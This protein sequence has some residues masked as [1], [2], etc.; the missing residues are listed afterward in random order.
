[1]IKKEPTEN[2]GRLLIT[3][4]LPSSMWIER[5]NLVGEFNGWDTRAT[6]M[7]RSRADTGWKATVELEA[8]R[9]YRFR[10]LVDGKR[11]LNDWHAD[12]HVEN[13]HGSFDSVLDLT[14]FSA[15]PHAG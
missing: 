13:A 2:S 12:D 15:S 14:S 9:R 5:A 11:W 3:F 1:M 6:P 8:G 10:Y 4:K 7:T